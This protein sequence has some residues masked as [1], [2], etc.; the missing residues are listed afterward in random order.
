M[1]SSLLNPCIKDAE[2]QIYTIT[3]VNDMQPIISPIPIPNP[4]TKASH[5]A[6][7]MHAKQHLD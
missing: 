5:C 2:K 7:K 6:S 1:L 4:I 3:K